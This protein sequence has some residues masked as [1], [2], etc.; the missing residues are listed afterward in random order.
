M[1]GS[2]ISIISRETGPCINVANLFAPASAAAASAF[3]GN[4]CNLAA[5]DSD[6]RGLTNI[7]AAP[8]NLS[9][10]MNKLSVGSVEGLLRRT[11]G[12]ATPPRPVSYTHLTLPTKR[13]V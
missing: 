8:G 7:S 10:L 3:S 1:S 6:E 12:M 13:I 9:L 2:H 11:T 5:I 4:V